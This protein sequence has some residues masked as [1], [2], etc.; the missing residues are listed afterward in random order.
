MKK[1]VNASDSI[2]WDE[3]L[4]LKSILRERVEDMLFE[5]FEEGLSDTIAKE[6]PEIPPVTQSE[7]LDFTA[8]MNTGAK[9]IEALVEG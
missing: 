2:N 6:F 9:Y 3:Y 5:Q 8:V 1:Y 7:L 4:D